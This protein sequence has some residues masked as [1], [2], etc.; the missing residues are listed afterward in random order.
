MTNL[1]LCF[2]K[3]MLRWRMGEA[4]GGELEVYCNRPGVRCQGLS[5]G[6]RSEHRERG[7]FSGDLDGGSSKT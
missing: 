3:L 7:A 2:R 6:G 4:L 5:Q 1:D